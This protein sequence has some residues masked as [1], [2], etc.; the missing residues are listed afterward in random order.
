M[1]VIKDVRATSVFDYTGIG[2]VNVPADYKGILHDAK[3]VDYL[4]TEPHLQRR[5]SRCGAWFDIQSKSNFDIQKQLKVDYTI[6]DKIKHHTLM[7]YQLL[8]G[9]VDAVATAV[10]VSFE[11]NQ[12]IITAGHTFNSFSPDK[13]FLYLKEP[14]IKISDCCGVIHHPSK[15]DDFTDMDF[16]L[17]YVDIDNVLKDALRCNGYEPFVI[18]NDIIKDLVRK[19][20]VA[21]GV[22]NFL[23]GYP[24][25][26]NSGNPHRVK[27]VFAPKPLCLDIPFDKILLKSDTKESVNER[28][29]GTNIET[30]NVN[31]VA[32]KNAVYTSNI[33][34]GNACMLPDLHC[35]S[36]CGVWDFAGYPYSSEQCC[37]AGMLLGATSDNKHIVSA[38]LV[39]IMS[40]IVATNELLKEKQWS[41]KNI[42]GM[43]RTNRSASTM[44]RETKD[45]LKTTYPDSV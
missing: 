20:E 15:V 4:K 18:D 34:T 6:E 23:Y 29:P 33:S 22:Y 32:K 10:Y 13:L 8:Y 44:D 9:E 36:G 19:D 45:L 17:I 40:N 41:I 16:A 24:C 28:Y 21:Y 14:R 38:K 25:K 43:L 27:K 26:K 12:Y 42:K 37:L 31:P 11:G 3:Q 35:M 30:N 7:I 39:D 5:C 2:D 1:G